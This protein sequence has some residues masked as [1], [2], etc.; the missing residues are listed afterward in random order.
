M[1]AG[2][3]TVIIQ[4]THGRGSVPRESGNRT[5]SV[6]PDSVFRK[7]LIMWLVGG[8][9]M[10]LLGVVLIFVSLLAVFAYMGYRSDAQQSTRVER[11]DHEMPVD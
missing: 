2:W 10:V 9:K 8:V 6:L 3:L 11:K 1:A 7:K 5:A 4:G